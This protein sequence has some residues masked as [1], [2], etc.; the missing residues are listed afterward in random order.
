MLT[1]ASEQGVGHDAIG[2]SNQVGFLVGVATIS[3]RAV[4]KI[5]G[6]QKSIGIL[7]L[8]SPHKRIINDPL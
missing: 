4:M 2:G 3:K 6:S 8:I 5:S 7:G 1:S